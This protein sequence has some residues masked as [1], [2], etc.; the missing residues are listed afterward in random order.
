MHDKN[1]NT[2]ILTLV[3]SV[4]LFLVIFCTSTMTGVMATA[5][6]TNSNTITRV[7][8]GKGVGTKPS[9]DFLMLNKSVDTL[10]NKG[11]ALFN[12]GKY[13][14]SIAYFDKALAINP[15]DII[16]L[17]N[18]GAALNKLGKYNESIAYFDT[19]LAKHPANHHALA[20]KED[21]LAAWNPS[22]F[23]FYFGS[24]IPGQPPANNAPSTNPSNST[25]T[26]ATNAYKLK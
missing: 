16:S 21:D 12:L 10:D 18:K 15:N 20:G 17:I 2:K 8:L 7:P 14:E 13:N 4:S 5:T 19:V 9:N 6:N 26:P 24:H 3:Y 1:L 25:A 11:A 22:T 23:G